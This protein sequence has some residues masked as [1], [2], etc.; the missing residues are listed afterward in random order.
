MITR[1]KV[2]FEI[3]LASKN[4]REMLSRALPFL[5]QVV[6]RPEVVRQ[7]GVGCVVKIPSVRVTE[8]AVQMLLAKM[9]VQLVGV[10]EA[11]FAKL[12]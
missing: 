2:T 11:F 5:A 4:G 6:V 12:A 1:H 3:N 7:G 10:H 9:P 8:M